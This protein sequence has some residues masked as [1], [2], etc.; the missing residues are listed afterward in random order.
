MEVDGDC[1]LVNGHMVTLCMRC[2]CMCFHLCMHARG[3]RGEIPPRGQGHFRLSTI[4]DVAF[5]W[6]PFFSPG[7][8]EDTPKISIGIIGNL[9]CHEVSMKYVV[10]SDKRID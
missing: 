4:A 3:T 9:A 2:G 5:L 10:V 8:S 7:L 1:G 6:F